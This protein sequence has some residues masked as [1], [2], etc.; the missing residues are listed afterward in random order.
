MYSLKAPRPLAAGVTLIFPPQ[1][2]QP[3]VRSGLNHARMFFL[4][5]PFLSVTVLQSLQ[6]SA[7]FSFGRQQASASALVF[8]RVGN[9][10]GHFD[11]VEPAIAE[12][13]NST[14]PMA[15]LA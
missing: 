2:E 11:V 5:S 3:C 7:T 13:L 15:R 4:S 9:P 6:A 14:V 12:V 10:A 1:P 8:T